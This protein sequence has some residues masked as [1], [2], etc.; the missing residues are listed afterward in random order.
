MYT[1]LAHF[2]PYKNKARLLISRIVRVT[3]IFSPYIESRM[4]NKKSVRNGRVIIEKRIVRL[5]IITFQK[6]SDVISN[7]VL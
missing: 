5:M 2:W 6:I 3:D 4:E 7:V 1:W